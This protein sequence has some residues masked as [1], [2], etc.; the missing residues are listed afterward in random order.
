[1]SIVKY[2]FEEPALLE[3]PA[4]DA[5]PDARRRTER[6]ARASHDP[7]ADTLRA[8]LNP[9]TAYRGYLA[10]TDLEAN[11]VGLT[12]LSV[13]DTMVHA[14]TAVFAHPHVCGIAPDG[15]LNAD[16][17]MQA[18]RSWWTTPQG[19][20][21]LACA[22]API[23][24]TPLHDVAQQARR[25]GSAALRTLMEAG[26]TV[27]FSEPAHDGFDWSFFSPAPVRDALTDALRTHVSANEVRCFVLP[28]QKARSESKFY[29]EQWQLN[30]ASLPTYIQEV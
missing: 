8:L 22:D 6:S 19:E 13:M 20:C 2:F 3:P 26:T 15:T 28:F 12:A 7:D 18:V 5:N 16:M 17:D 1:M 11:R 14:L 27:F 23:D 25:E 29:F 4:S 10:G 30:Q 9:A 24:P 21:V